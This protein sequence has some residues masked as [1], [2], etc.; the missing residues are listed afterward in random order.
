MT[1]KYILKYIWRTRDYM[2]M[3]HCDELLPF[4]YTNLDSQS[5]RDPH[6]FSFKFIFTLGSGGVSWK[7]VK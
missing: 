7:S 3:Y 5:N 4:R 2:L 6:K 1:V